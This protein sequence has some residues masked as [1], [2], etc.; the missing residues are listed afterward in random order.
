MG[1]GSILMFHIYWNVNSLLLLLT[2]YTFKDIHA[3][4]QNRKYRHLY[5]DFTR[6]SLMSATNYILQTRHVTSLLPGRGLKLENILRFRFRFQCFTLTLQNILMQ[7]DYLWTH[8][9]ISVIWHKIWQSAALHCEASIIS[10]K[11]AYFLVHCVT[12]RSPVNL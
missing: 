4:A 2:F 11:I 6:S 5:T 12:G 9:N 1:S 3:L 7:V 8:V 10:I